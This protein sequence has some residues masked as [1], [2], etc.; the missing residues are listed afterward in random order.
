MTIR[1]NLKEM[2]RSKS[3][4]EGL[5]KVL[6]SERKSL[7]SEIIRLRDSP[8]RLFSERMAA[9]EVRIQRI[10][11]LSPLRSGSKSVCD[12]SGLVDERDSAEG[13]GVVKK[14][15]HNGLEGGGQ[16]GPKKT[17]EGVKRVAASDVKGDKLQKTSEIK[18]GVPE[19][20][21]VSE[22]LKNESDGEKSYSDVVGT[23]MESKNA[24]EKDVSKK[25]SCPIATSKERGLPAPSP[26]R[27]SPEEI[28]APEVS[29]EVS[30]F[31]LVVSGVEVID[32]A[33]GSEEEETS[34]EESSESQGNAASSFRD[35]SKTCLC[36]PESDC[37]IDAHFGIGLDFV[38]VGKLDDSVN[39]GKQSVGLGNQ[40]HQVFD[41]KSE[42]H[43]GSFLREGL[44][45]MVVQAPSESVLVVGS[46][47][48]GSSGSQ[49]G[50]KASVQPVGASSWASIVASKG[51]P[52]QPIP[53]LNHRSPCRK[54]EQLILGCS[55]CH[56]AELGGKAA[57]QDQQEL[58]DKAAHPL[59]QGLGCSAEKQV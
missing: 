54:K 48:K 53:R 33:E 31:P 47:S 50:G 7:G 44:A 45:S 41:E 38:D 10:K 24:D 6:R 5:S 19:T 4:D 1:G 43:L 36:V 16:S 23:E 34:D 17:L 29:K 39:Q 52:K 9:I 22:M 46:D 49:T 18:A 14:A 26:V 13:D 58:A 3:M 8:K 30:P 37:V 57:L 55:A 27:S 28:V 40:A 56:N 25:P 11:S 12:V 32:S 2:F 21:V 20:G 35:S 42:P 15:G 51:D 59:G